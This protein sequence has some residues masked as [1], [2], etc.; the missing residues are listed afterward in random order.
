LIGASLPDVPAIAFA[1]VVGFLGYGVSLALFV[2]ALRHLGTARTGA[3]FSTAP[4]LGSAAAVI[5]LG[6]PLSLPLPHY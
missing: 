6:E 2:V 3:C 1:S 4:F 5:V